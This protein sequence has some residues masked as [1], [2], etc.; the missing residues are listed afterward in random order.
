[1][2]ED[3]GRLIGGELGKAFVKPP[4]RREREGGRVLCKER[5]KRR[6]E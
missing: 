2:H 1:M 3:R 5:A 6:N 4:E